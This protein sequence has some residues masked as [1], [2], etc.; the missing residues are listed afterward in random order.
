MP[1]GIDA[2]VLRDAL[3]TFLMLVISLSV[4]EWAHAWTALR[5]GDPTAQ[6]QGRVTFNPMAHIDPIGTVILP[7]FMLLFRASTGAMIFVPG[8][9]KPVPVNPTYFRH[10]VRD[11]LLVTLAGPFSNLVLCLMGATIGGVLLRF[12]AVEELVINFVWINAG[13]C[14]F[15]LVVAVPPLDGS[16]V[17]RHLVGMSEETYL[18]MCQWGPF[19]L[20]LLIN[21]SAVRE[22]VGM[23]TMK[24]SEPFFKLAALI[25]YA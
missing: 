4:H 11:D 24:C 14:V 9:A 3:I 19:L 16:H 13:L 1:S 7:L 21:I 6:M 17:L 5:V 2:N 18:R 25:R 12:A 22:F 8:W 10:K 15:N 23:L 20:I